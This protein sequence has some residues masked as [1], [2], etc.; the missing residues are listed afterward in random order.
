MLISNTRKENIMKMKTNIF[1]RRNSSFFSFSGAMPY[2]LLAAFEVLL[3][4]QPVTGLTINMTDIGATPMTATQ[5]NAFQEAADKWESLYRDPVTVQ[6]DIAFEALSGG[7][8]GSTRSARTT[9]SYTSVRAA[10]VADA[11]TSQEQAAVNSLPLTSVQ[12]T[13]ISGSRFDDDVT[14][15][16]ANAKALGLGTG[17]DTSYT[18]PPSGVDATIKFSTSYSSEF[19]YNPDDGVPADKYDFVGIA[20][21]EIGHALGFITVTDIQDNNPTF[22]LH[23]HT[24]D[25]YRFTETGGSHNI[26]TSIRYVTHGGAEY[27]D[28]S[29][30]N[31]PLSHGSMECTDPHCHTWSGCCQASHWD[32]DQEN[33]MDPSVAT[34]V[35]QTVKSDDIHALDYIGWNQKFFFKFYLV[36]YVLIGWFNPYELPNIPSFERKFEKFP[37]PPPPEIIPWPPNATLALRA[38]FDFDNDTPLRSGLGYARFQPVQKIEPRIVESLKP[39]KGEEYL[40]PPGPPMSVL[41]QNL[42]EVFIQSDLKNVPFRFHSLCGETGCPFDPSLGKYGGY[43]VPGFIDGEGDDTAGDADGLMTLVLLVSDESGLPKPDEENTFASSSDIK[44]NSL[45]VH[46]PKGLGPIIPAVCGDAQ[47][48]IPLADLDRNCVVDLYD[49]ALFADEWLTCTAPVCP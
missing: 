17:L 1:Y 15:S 36:K 38:G 40:D 37:P 5:L 27:Y 12:I 2:L 9:H 48:P 8:L 31:V 14:M 19:D 42:S 45:I 6:I 47:H 13:D 24:L 43:R 29:L 41:P 33:L 25:L 49:L 10:M 46:D 16:T 44:D 20:T 35:I 30:N 4:T 11:A 34:G 18:N 7:V 28:S 26:T 3:L 32:D 23:P 21:H 39:V 22:T